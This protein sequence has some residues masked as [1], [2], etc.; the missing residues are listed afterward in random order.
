[1]LTYDDLKHK[2]RELLAATSLKQDEFESL[3]VSFEKVYKEAQP[4]DRTQTGQPR[5]RKVGAGNKSNLQPIA[6]KLLFILVYHKTYPLQTMLGLQVGLSQG[7]VN[8]WIHR[9]TPLLQQAL[10]AQGQTP[11][12]D[13][14]AV[15]TSEL[16]VEGG[17]DLVI[18]GTERRRNVRRTKRHSKST[19]VAKKRTP[20]KT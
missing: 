2:P 6:D 19:T 8:E 3:L 20:I 17:A 11:A 5:Q 10:A 16:A 13:G 18:D 15:Q 1:M 12:R 9:L 4:K 7:R 14:E